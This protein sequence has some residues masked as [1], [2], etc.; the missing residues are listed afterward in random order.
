VLVF[1]YAVLCHIIIWWNILSRYVMHEQNIELCSFGVKRLPP[2]VKNIVFLQ[3]VLF[4]LFG[5]VPVSQ[6]VYISCRKPVG[7]T[8]GLA[9][10]A[11]GVLSVIS[12]GLLAIMFVKLITDGNCIYTHEGKASLSWKKWPNSNIIIMDGQTMYSISCVSLPKM[13]FKN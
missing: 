10:L 5:L 6:V 12:K 11:Y 9:T 2:I 7:S 13:G 4:S 8:F 1:S 3:C